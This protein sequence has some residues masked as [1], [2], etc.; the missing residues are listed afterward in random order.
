MWYH[1]GRGDFYEEPEEYCPSIY[2]AQVV[3]GAHT[4]C[5]S[6][7]EADLLPVLR[8]SIQPVR[9]P[10]PWEIDGGFELSCEDIRLEEHPPPDVEEKTEAA[11]ESPCIPR[12]LPDKAHPQMDNGPRTITLITTRLELRRDL[13]GTGA[14]ISATGIRSILHRFQN[15]SDYQIKGYDGQVTKAAGQGYAQIYNPDTHQTDEML[16]VY[17]PAVTGTIISLEHHARTHPLHRWTHTKR[18]P[19]RAMIEGRLRYLMRTDLWC[20]LTIRSAR[21][22][23]T[24]S[25]TL[26]L[27]RC[28]RLGMKTDIRTRYRRNW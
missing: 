2:H 15:H 9:Y 14:S 6:E 16:F 25:K 12:S 10:F 3:E 26:I 4:Q 8:D 13:A 11:T 24:T 18:R 19:R 28:R 20:P 1:G 7:F 27:F 21:G 5:V 17:T 22:A 23:C